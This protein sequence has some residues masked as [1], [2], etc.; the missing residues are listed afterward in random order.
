[1]NS[2]NWLGK[3]PERWNVLKLRQIL[4]PFSEKNHPNM[5]LLSV[6]REKGVIIRNIEDK[7]ENNNYVPD[8]LSGYKLV[9]KGQFAMNKMKAWQG[10][11][12]ISKYDGIVSPAYF[13]FDINHDMNKDFFNLAIRSKVYVNYFGQS[14]DGI[15]VGQWDLSMKRMKEIPFF[16]PPRSEQDQIVKFLDWKVSCINKLISNYREQIRSF[17]E[18]R[19]ALVDTV[20]THG[21]NKNITL[22]SSS[23]SWIKKIPKHWELIKLK[24][25]VTLSETK[26]VNSKLPYIGMENVVSWK[27]TYHIDNKVVP[28]SVCPIFSSGN[29]LFGK[30]RPYLAKAIITESDGICSG[31]FLVFKNIKCNTKFLLYY[32]LSQRFIDNINSSTYGAKMPRANWSYIGTQFIP[33][34]PDVEQEEIVLYLD[35]QCKKIDEAVNII[36]KKI[37]NLLELRTCLISNVITGKIDIRNIEIPEYDS[38]EEETD[39]IVADSEIEEGSEE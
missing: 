9:K 38:V 5:P 23:S 11:Y 32:L 2:L 30:L 12:G 13:V 8:D 27:G 1:M 35:M 4:T 29:I 25:L 34:P 36:D 37:S 26:V 14:S 24:R 22:K 21:L 6:V 39:N 31:E 3:V 7:E 33:V 19:I 28:E 15:R 17:Q 10:S 20:I 18:F 16:L